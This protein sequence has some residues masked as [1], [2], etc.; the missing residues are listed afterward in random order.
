MFLRNQSKSI[1]ME[2]RF[3][4]VHSVGKSLREFSA[5]IGCLDWGIY[6]TKL[7]RL[8]FPLS[9]GQLIGFA[10]YENQKAGPSFPSILGGIQGV[11][12]F[13]SQSDFVIQAEEPFTHIAQATGSSGEFV[14]FVASG[15][16]PGLILNPSDGNLSGIPS[17]AGSYVSE[18]RA[19]YTDGSQA[20]QTY[21][22]EILA[23]APKSP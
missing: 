10:S 12:S 15:L 22:F 2:L 8:D 4:A 14:A 19:I 21:T 18:F 17:T 16:P 9:L 13:T 7:M 6:H 1:R 5:K 23:G 20:S 3:T 11:H